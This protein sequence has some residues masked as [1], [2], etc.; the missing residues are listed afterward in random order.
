MCTHVTHACDLDIGHLAAL[1]LDKVGGCETVSQR[2]ARLV[3]QAGLT[4]DGALGDEAG[5]VTVAQAVGDHDLLNIANLARTVALVRG[6]GR[7]TPQAKVIDGVDDDLQGESQLGQGF[8]ADCT[9]VYLH[10]GSCWSGCYRRRTCCSRTGPAR[11]TGAGCQRCRSPCTAPVRAGR[12]A[13]T[14]RRGGRSFFLLAE[15]GCSG[16]GQGD[17]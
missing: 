2:Y 9:V 10:F 15:S 1:D 11:T 17:G 13:G 4:G 7:R 6:R 8:E 14:E 3:D 12:R 5:T 16:F